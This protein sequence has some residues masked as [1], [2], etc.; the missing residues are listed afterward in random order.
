MSVKIY[1]FISVSL[2]HKGIKYIKIKKN[3]I[4]KFEF[5]TNQILLKQTRKNN[6]AFI[7]FCI[8]NGFESRIFAVHINEMQN[9][10]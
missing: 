7:Y 1:T 3:K 9:F 10:L 8:R 4:T 2:S 5:L 6:N